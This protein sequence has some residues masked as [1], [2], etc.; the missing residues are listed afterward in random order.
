MATRNAM[1]KANLKMIFLLVLLV[2]SVGWLVIE[3]NKSLIPEYDWEAMEKMPQHPKL[4]FIQTTNEKGEV[5]IEPRTL[6]T[7]N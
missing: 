7:K 2:F 6:T 1:L 4:V 5:V 3:L